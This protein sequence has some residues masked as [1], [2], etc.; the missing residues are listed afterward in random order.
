MDFFV[1]KKILGA[2]LMPL[3]V[4]I[5]LLLVG[6]LALVFS[7]RRAAIVAISV[8]LGLLI[9][10]TTTYTPNK[11]LGPLERSYPQ[12]D[13]STSVDYIVILG[14]GHV[15]DSV[16]PLSSQLYPCSMMRIAEAMRIYQHNPGARFV[17][18]G[19]LSS[20]PFSNAE[21]NERMLIAMGVAPSAVITVSKSRDTEEESQNLAAMLQG[22]RF[23]LVTSASHM[24]RAKELFEAQGL[25]P[26]PAPSEHLVRISD[27]TNFWS[28]LPHS[29]NI[30]KFERWWY[31]RLGRTWLDVKSLF[32]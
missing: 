32:G 30:Q 9:V 21:M 6:W 4:I 8:S 19:A 3:P 2:L 31:E 24:I 16:L 1:L 14:C 26:I 23:A 7:K 17:T 20:Q 12:F 13:L 11:L 28:V 25:S 27:Q 10:T 18:S 29:K 5:V 15:N 22:K